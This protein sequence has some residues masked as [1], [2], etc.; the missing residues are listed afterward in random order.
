[1]GQFREDVVTRNMKRYRLILCLAACLFVLSGCNGI[2]EKKA[3]DDAT[4]QELVQT[5]QIVVAYAFYPL[6]ET[7]AAQFTSQGAETIESTFSSSFNIA[8]DGEAMISAFDSW[9][10]AAAKIGAAQKFMGYSAAYNTSG[11]SI[12]VNVSIQAE[13]GT[14]Q[15]EFVFSDDPDHKIM[16]SSTKVDHAFGEWVEKIGVNTLAVIGAVM[17]AVIVLTAVITYFIAASRIQSS[18]RKKDKT[19]EKEMAV[20][21]TIAQIIEK[22]ERIDDVE[23]MAVITAI[24]AASQAAGP[25][26]G[27]GNAAAGT[28][29]FLARKIKRTPG[30]RWGRI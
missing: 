3:V 5:A 14:A 19:E 21:N 25:K 6:D 22:E 4:A 26:A 13:K 8:V 11:D 16:A 2:S 30:S 24:I 9:N 7:S 27:R 18:F 29:G 17:V 23:M 10:Q 1:M 15:V 12:I 20:N 28:D